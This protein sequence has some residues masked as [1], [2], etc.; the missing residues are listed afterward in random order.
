[1]IQCTAH[2][3]VPTRICG[4]YCFCVRELGHAGFCLSYHHGW[5]FHWLRSTSS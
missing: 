5:P 1:M 2:F 3:R 4:Q